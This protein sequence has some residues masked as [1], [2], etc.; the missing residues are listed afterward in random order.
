MPKRGC[1]NA[2]LRRGTAAGNDHNRTRRNRRVGGS[3]RTRTGSSRVVARASAGPVEPML[4][5]SLPRRGPS[6]GLPFR[7]D[8]IQHSPRQH[9]EGSPV[10]VFQKRL[11]FRFLFR[12]QLSRAALA[13][14]RVEPPL[15]TGRQA[16]WGRTPRCRL[17][18]RRTRFA[19][20]S[21]GHPRRLY[22]KRKSRNTTPAQGITQI[23]QIMDQ[24]RQF[25]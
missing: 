12:R 7:S 5:P 25:V 21:L 1:R 22:Q 19:N 8:S 3:R 15:L 4:R 2:S 23:L 13:Q 16:V 10:Y 11:E 24:T 14:Q 17:V 9:P 20:H 6:P 18:A